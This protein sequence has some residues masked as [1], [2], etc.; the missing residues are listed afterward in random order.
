MEKKGLL[1]KQS[2]SGAKWSDIELWKRKKL[3]N[4]V[5][6]TLTTLMGKNFRLSYLMEQRFI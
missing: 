1:V 3:K 5:Y 4:L 2:D 6:N